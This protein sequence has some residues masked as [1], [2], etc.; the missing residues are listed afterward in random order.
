MIGCQENASSDGSV[1]AASNAE[2]NRNALRKHNGAV[3][4]DQYELEGYRRNKNK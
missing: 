1:V 4:S 3:G 2:L